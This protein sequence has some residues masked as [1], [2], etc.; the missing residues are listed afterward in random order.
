MTML[1]VGLTG[2]IGCGKSTAVDAFRDFGVAIVDADKIARDVVAKGQPALDEIKQS[3]GKDIV[4]DDGEL[5]RPALKK[6][7]FEASQQGTI[8]LEHLEKILHPRIRTEIQRQITELEYSEQYDKSYI[9]V[10]IPLLVEKKYQDLFDH[11]VVVDCLPEQQ[12]ARVI[13]RDGMDEAS[14]KNIMQQQASRVERLNIATE[15]LDN[16][17]NIEYLLAQVKQL[18]E[19]F[20]TLS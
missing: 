18:H 1:K 5:N 10:D 16:G 17:G 13:D 11:I 15:V 8:N 20:V 14:V 6:I 19:K 12:I 3:F 2:G 9:I 4:L 7:I